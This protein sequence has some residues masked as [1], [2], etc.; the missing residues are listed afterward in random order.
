ME[1]HGD[2]RDREGESGTE[3]EEYEF[4]Q[5]TLK[6]EK[7]RG[8]IGK[9]TIIKCAAL[10]LVFGMAA[11]LGFF[12]LKPWAEDLMLGDPDEITIPEEEEDE[13]NTA[14][15]EEEQSLVVSMDHYREMSAALT[16]IADKAKYSMAR[17]SVAA[18]DTVDAENITGADETDA[19]GTDSV[20]GVIIAD[21]GQE[22]LVFGSNRV[23]QAGEAVEVTF[24][25]GRSYEAGVK[26]SDGT[27][28]Y[29]VYAVHKSSLA[30]S[31]AEK[32]QVATLGRTGTAE[33]G[34]TVIAMG[35]PFGYGDSIGYGV[36]A[37]SGTE[38]NRTDGEYQVIGTDISGTSDGTGALFN[39][40]GEVVGMIDAAARDEDMATVTA[41]GISDLKAMIEC[42]SNGETVP[43][44][45]ITG[46][47]V[48]EEIASDQGIPRGVYVQ[49]VE[50]DSPAMEA[51]IQS[52]DVITEVAKTAVTTLS[53]YHTV[54]MKQKTGDSIRVKGM[55]KG[56]DD[57]VD[58]QYNVTVGSFR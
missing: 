45:G 22:Y 13:G 29:A 27:L 17:I 56:T 53:A 46:V 12:A 31:T 7:K 43:Y 10:G 44:L 6:D 24:A 8:R 34:N 49:K 30:A 2:P 11:S 41:Y 4:L 57:Y 16:E 15:A 26:Q 38:K 14:T 9:S 40:N 39:V 52:G 37:S 23:C 3:H 55:R 19:A 5:E 42:L 33:Q 51:G 20:T 48:T 25:D 28:G 35:D 50:A 18:D 47:S 21:N 32:I 58:V 1:N 36:I 54:L